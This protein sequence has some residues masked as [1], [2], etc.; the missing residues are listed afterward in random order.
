MVG[1]LAV[2]VLA[3]RDF[4]GLLVILRSPSGVTALREMHGELAGDLDRALTVC[5]LEPLARPQVQ[6]ARRPTGRRP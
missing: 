6:C 3:E 1:G 2:P 5:L 4:R